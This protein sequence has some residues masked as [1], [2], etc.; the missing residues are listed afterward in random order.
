MA[1]MRKPQLTLDALFFST[2]QQKIMRLLLSESTT[3]FT[4]R[5]ISS[6]LK[7]VRGIGGTEGLNKILDELETIGLVD[8]VDNHRAVRLRDDNPVVQH[9]KVFTAVCDLENLRD[10]AAPISAKA[11][12]FGSRAIGKARSDSDYDIFV[13]SD[14]PEE[15]KKLIAHHPLRKSIE[16]VVW[17]PEMYQ[18]IETTDPGLLRKLEKGIVLWGSNW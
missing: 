18:E 1:K 5:T 8:Y 9:L 2:P 3:V 15:V 6:K 14:M 11:V 13:V 16:L 12:L 10:L 4:T 17:T 7:G